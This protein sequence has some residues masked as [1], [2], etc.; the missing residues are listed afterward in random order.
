[1]ARLPYFDA[2]SCF[3]FKW[4]FKK[5]FVKAKQSISKYVHEASC[6][7]TKISVVIH[8]QMFFFVFRIQ[9]SLK[10]GSNCVYA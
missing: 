7:R 8:F 2:H 1:M 9:A 10:A 3:F 6:S 4:I 5:E